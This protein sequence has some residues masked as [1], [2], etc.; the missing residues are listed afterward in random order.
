M[1]VRL[2]LNYGKGPV[3]L[4]NVAEKEDIS[5]KYLGQI[6]ISLKAAGLIKTV[7]GFKGGNMLTKA[8]SEYTLLEIIEAI[9]GRL[10]LIDCATKSGGCPRENQC[11]TKSIWADLNDTV[12]GKLQEKS[13]ADLLV[14]CGNNSEFHDFSI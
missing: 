11:L 8:P 5:M 6:A 3:D 9:E 2:A 14:E 7:R 12:R 4:R 13:L 1:M 10:S